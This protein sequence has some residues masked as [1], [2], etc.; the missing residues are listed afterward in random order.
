MDITTLIIKSLTILENLLFKKTVRIATYVDKF[1]HK[2]YW[3]IFLF[4][5][6]SFEMAASFKNISALV[7][8]I[9]MNNVPNQKLN[10]LYRRIKMNKGYNYWNVIHSSFRLNW[11]SIQHIHTTISHYC[12]SEFF[13][14]M[15]LCSI[16]LHVSL[17]Q[18]LSKQC[19]PT[20]KFF[21]TIFVGFSRKS[22]AVNIK[23]LKSS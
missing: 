19:L 23:L 9:I 16:V 14:K 3:S 12:T 13:L 7:E 11:Y 1:Q 22:T 2:K 15:A 8:V 5:L 18:M 21:K 17:N 6:Y 4:L 20:L 10:W